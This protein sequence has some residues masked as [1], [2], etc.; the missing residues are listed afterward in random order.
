MP[1]GFL[2]IGVQKSGTTMLKHVLGKHKQLYLP[3]Q[4]VHYFD[5]NYSK[6]SE[7]YENHFANQGKKICGEKTPNYINS[8]KCLRN[9]RKDYPNIKIIVIFRNPVTRALSHWN[10]FNQEVS[11]GNPKGDWTYEPEFSKC[12]VSNH[13]V[14]VNGH[15]FEKLQSVYKHFESKQILLL[16]NE[17][18]EQQPELMDNLYQFIGCRIPKYKKLQKIHK[19]KYNDQPRLSDI[20]LLIRYYSSRL[21][22]F[23][24]LLGFRVKEWDQYFLNF[25]QCNE[26]TFIER[27][28]MNNETTFNGT[29]IIVCVNYSDFLGITLPIN[30]RFIKNILV[31]TTT[32]DKDTQELCRLHGIQYIETNVFYEPSYS[33]NSSKHWCQKALSYIKSPMRLF[34][35]KIFNKAKAINLAVNTVLA[36][37]PGE[38]VLLLDADIVL[39]PEIASVDVNNLDRD[40]LYGTERV[41]YRTKDDWTTKS[42]AYLDRH[43]FMGFFQLFHTSSNNF[44]K[45]YFCYNE[46]YNYAD[47][48]DYEFAKKWPT[49]TLLEFYS[50]HLGETEQNWD[51]RVTERWDKNEEKKSPRSGTSYIM[52]YW[53]YCSKKM[54]DFKD[55]LIETLIF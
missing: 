3:K 35:R 5:N 46:K 29:C 52:T 51:G 24:D 39:P 26:N 34:K 11:R 31:V 42:N 41:V 15:Y 6:G 44:T 28:L 4:E 21:E 27:P 20:K 33:S 47:L 7:W 18:L 13:S 19:R 14:L 53:K 38:W 37:K 9:I 22:Q 1:P 49:K 23:Y 10:H 40:T 45:D 30:S 43:K 36:D 16:F 2:I 50:V 54:S 32:G 25:Y 55:W 48:S 8:D 17:E 12:I